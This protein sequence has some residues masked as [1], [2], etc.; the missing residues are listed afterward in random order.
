MTVNDAGGTY[1][2]SG[3]PATGL[4]NGAAT[5]ETMGTTLAYYVGTMATGTALSMAPT[6]AGIYTV[7]ASFA[8]SAVYT[9][10]TSSPLTFNI[11]KGR[12]D[13]DGQRCR[14]DV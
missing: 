14:R 6:V 13:C 8:G 7:V 4:V 11:S 3:F 5:L 2:G 1:S 12:A 10:A 9:S